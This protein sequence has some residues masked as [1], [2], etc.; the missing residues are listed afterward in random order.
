MAA[1]EKG[2]MKIKQQPEDFQVEELTDVTPVDKGPYAFYRLEKR[3]W[4]T[5]DAVQAIRR[6]WQLDRRRVAHGGLKDRHAHTVQ[7]LTIFHGPQRNLTHQRLTLTYLGLAAKEYGSASFRGNRFRI[8]VRSL[9][10]AALAVAQESLEETRRQGVPNYFD[11]QRFGSVGAH[12]EFMARAL[13]AGDYEEALRRAL[14]APYEF[15]RGAQKK[16]K[17]VLRSHWGEWAACKE[18]L[19]RGHARRLVDYLVRHPQD[20][21]GA[22]DCLPPDLRGLYL[23]AYQSH[24]WNRMLSHWLRRHVAPDHLISLRLRLGDVPAHRHL[25]EPELAELAE[26]QL[27]LPSPKV[28]LDDADPRKEVYDAVL[29]EEGLRQEQFKLK[30]MREMFFSRGDRAALCLPANLHHESGADEL[31]P[32]KQK[33]IFTCELPRGSYATLLVKRMT[34]GTR[35]G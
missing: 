9:S 10:E 25:S 8:T 34:Q 27:P 21:R 5:P 30:G 4:T 26:V 19:P 32:K 35:S 18:T 11:D 28:E 23:S 6:R 17:A 2:F 20:F 29:N 16:E 22:L 24:L 15:D 1:K 13:V 12:G 33:L 31:N 3:G 7:Y 14:L